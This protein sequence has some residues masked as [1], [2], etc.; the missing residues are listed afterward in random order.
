MHGLGTKGFV[1]R[2]GVTEYDMVLFACA[3]A[4]RADVPAQVLSA[5]A[6][7]RLLCAPERVLSEVPACASGRN[8][9]H[10]AKA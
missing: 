1:R 6:G 8:R 7:K 3:M 4:Y 5:L 10:A 2:Y 9:D